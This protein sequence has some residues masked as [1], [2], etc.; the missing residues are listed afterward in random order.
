MFA[1]LWVANSFETHRE[2]AD[3]IGFAHMYICVYT[4]A[5]SSEWEA[6]HE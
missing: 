5:I 6:G 4:P 3:P 1:N 2:T